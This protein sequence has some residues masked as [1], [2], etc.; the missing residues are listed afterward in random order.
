MRAEAALADAGVCA[1]SSPGS[2]SVST[3]ARLLG[4]D[5]EHVVSRAKDLAERIPDLATSLLTRVRED[6]VTHDA[7]ARLADRAS[8]RAR[9]CAASLLLSAIVTTRS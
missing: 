1:A 6:G 5:E 8:A 9:E 3:S 7:V 2:R 4:L